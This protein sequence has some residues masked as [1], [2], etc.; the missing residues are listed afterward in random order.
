MSAVLTI[1]KKELRVYA[2]SPLAYVFFGVFLFLAGVFF[3]LGIAL[4][5]EASLRVM[6]GNVAVSLLFVLPMVTMR[7]FAE[8]Q[9]AGTLELLMTAPISMPT[10]IV[11]KWLASMALCLVMLL[12]TLLFPAILAYYGDP[13]WGVIIT[14]YVGLVCCCA[15]FCA[16]G[17]FTSSLT[18]DQVAAGMGGIVILMPF[19]LIG[20]AGAIVGE[21]HQRLLDQIALLPHLRSFTRGVLD[22]ADLAYFVGFTFIFLF[23]TY[24]TLESRR[25]R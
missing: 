9:R 7:H 10:L 5:G 19:W 3:Y 4:T 1:L 23:L 2:V 15:A 13:D 25:W 16:A 17:L 12:G 21:E 11:G 8:E 14:S 18:N 6:L 24:R 22:T 20:S